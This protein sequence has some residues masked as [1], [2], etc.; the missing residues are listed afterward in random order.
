MTAAPPEERSHSPRRVLTG[1]AGRTAL[2]VA[3]VVAVLDGVLPRIADHSAAWELVWFLPVP[4][5]FATWLLW[6]HGAGQDRSAP[7]GAG[8]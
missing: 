8:P 4:T 5:G 1:P 3:V 7:A 2:A 6:R